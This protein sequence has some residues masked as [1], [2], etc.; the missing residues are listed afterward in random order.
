MK[1]FHRDELFYF[2]NYDNKVERTKNLIIL[3]KLTYSFL[4]QTLKQTTVI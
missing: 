1:S 2:K 3:Q 4:I